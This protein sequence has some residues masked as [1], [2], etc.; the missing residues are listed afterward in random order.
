M[1]TSN[2]KPKV[3]MLSISYGVFGGTEL[4]AE[5]LCNWLSDN[6]VEVVVIS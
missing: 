2:K 1:I 5:R 6:G 3:L 4:S